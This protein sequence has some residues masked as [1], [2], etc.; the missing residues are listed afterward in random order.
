MTTYTYD[1]ADRRIASVNHLTHATTFTYTPSGRVKTE[2]DPLLNTTTYTYDAVDR[3]ITVQRPLLMTATTAYDDNGNV[4]SQTDFNG[5]TTTF[6]YDS[7]DRMLTRTL[8]GPMVETF[9]YDAVGN[10]ETATDTRGVTTWTYDL[11]DRLTQR[12]DPDTTVVQYEYDLVGNRTALV[13]PAGRTEYAYDALNRLVTVTAPDLSVTTYTYDAANNL[14]SIARP[15]GTTTTY[16]QDLLGRLTGISTEDSTTA[17]IASYTCTL[18]TRGNRTQVIDGYTGRTVDYTYDA[19]SRLPQEQ[20]T[21]ADAETITYTYDAVGNRLTRISSVVGATTYAYD[22]NDSLLNENAGAITYGYDNNGNVVQ[23]VSGGT[24]VDYTYDGLNRLVQVDDGT[25]AVDYTYDVDANRVQRIVSGGGTINFL[26]DANRTFVQVIRETNGG[27]TGLA[28]YIHGLDLL[29]QDRGGGTSY[30]HYD[31][32][33]STRQLTNAGGVVTDTYDYDAFGV[34]RTTTGTTANDH[35]YAGEHND[36]LGDLVYLRARW[37][38]PSVGRFLSEDPADALL[39][40]PRTLNRYV[41][42]LNNPVNR[43]DPSGGFSLAGMMTAVSISKILVTMAPAITTGLA[44]IAIINAFWEPGFELRNAGLLIMSSTTNS[45]LTELAYRMHV[46]GT[47]LIELGAV[48]I[49]LTR[50]LIDLTFAFAGLASSIN[51]LVNSVKAIQAIAR[52]LLLANTIFSLASK[53]N[54]LSQSMQNLG[55]TLGANSQGASPQPAAQSE[56]NTIKSVAK[57]IVKLALQIAA[58]I[59]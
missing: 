9:T 4:L 50:T 45:I 2:T 25:T 46:G 33:T 7:N 32:Q 43:I 40:D 53:V 34:P 22:D 13:S 35:R 17:I 12:T 39:T 38:Q 21:G 59:E 44:T 6:T 16:T 19:L 49:D 15:D 28:T 31:P 27:G 47:A 3:R 24:T 55:N 48:L 41:Y 1:A 52:E 42:A 54:A 18:D 36:P 30:Y 5:D 20:I 26:I 29:C 8:P 56:A 14:D 51:S 37:M 10:R 57:E 11:L 23:R 58:A